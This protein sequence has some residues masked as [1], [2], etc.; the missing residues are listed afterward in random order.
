M[1]PVLEIRQSLASI[2]GALI[3][4]PPQPAPWG[5]ESGVEFTPLWDDHDTVD[6]TAGD[7]VDWKDDGDFSDD[8][9]RERVPDFDPIFEIGAEMEKAL[10]ALGNEGM[11]AI[12]RSVLLHGVDALGWYSSFHVTGV[13]WGA[14]VSMSGIA[15]LV[16]EV[17]RD[18]AASLET[19]LQLAF[20]AILNHEL[21]HF[22]TDYAIAQAELVH[23]EP[24]W[25]PAKRAFIAASPHYCTQEEKA[26]NAY[27]LKAFRSMKP[28]LRLRGK[29]QAL[30]NWTY[31]QPPGYAEGGLVER[32]GWDLTLHC[33]AGCY[34]DYSR[35]GREN[36]N[37][38]ELQRGYD[39]PHQFPIRPRIDWRY[40]PIHL[41]HD[42]DRLGIPRDYLNLFSRLPVIE[43]T[44][45]FQRSLQ[46]LAP[47][48]QQGW[49]R[50]KTKLLSCISRG[51]DFKKWSRA[52]N[53][54]W[55]VRINNSYR[56]HLQYDPDG[57]WRALAI[58]SHKEMGHG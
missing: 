26:A 58:G 10:P 41:V 5:I 16:R 35:I 13:Q 12:R 14:Y 42:G 7:P 43:E 19:K 56:A 55:S 37:L 30:R 50:T 34:L 33:L 52:G 3:E 57:V 46:S 24:W 39:W 8:P 36:D 2:P 25:V 53:N 40:C 44:K 9:H 45:D 32:E 18:L 1:R 28:A 21:F 38:W 49:I 6:S 15:Y 51:A 23:Q 29:Q 17:F 20:H 54:V 22:A 11:D 4:M 31:K 48:I 47:A 27:M